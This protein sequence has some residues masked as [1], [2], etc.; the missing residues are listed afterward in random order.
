MRLYDGR[1]GREPGAV[2]AVPQHPT[3]HYRAQ[4]EQVRLISRPFSTMAVSHD[5]RGGGGNFNDRTFFERFGI[6]I[7][8]SALPNVPIYIFMQLQIKARILRFVDLKNINSNSLRPIWIAVVT[9]SYF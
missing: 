7:Y 1:G 8:G 3:R 9:I 6:Y 5:K 4:V 2:Q